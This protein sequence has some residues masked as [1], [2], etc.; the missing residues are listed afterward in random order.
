MSEPA[1]EN[2]DDKKQEEEEEEEVLVATEGGDQPL[3]ENSVGESES[4]AATAAPVEQVAGE[5]PVQLGER[6]ASSSTAE[7][8]EDTGDAGEDSDTQA[9]TAE[10]GP[11]P[12]EQAGDTAEVCKCIPL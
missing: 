10:E 1:T 9:T 2:S 7:E 4:A 11:A 3:V 5:E 12:S 8:G 6:G